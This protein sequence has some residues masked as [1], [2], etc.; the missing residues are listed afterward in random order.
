MTT[1]IDTVKPTE[2]YLEDILLQALNGRSEEEYLT[3]Y[4]DGMV[5]RLK[6]NPQ[7]YHLYGPWWPALKTL[8]LERGDISFGQVVDSDV[9]EIYKMSRPALTVLAGHLYSSD[10]LGNDAVYNPVHALEVA[11]YADDTEPYVYI[12]YDESIE[13]YRIMG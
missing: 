11:P 2:S 1:L 12:S 13:K 8:L 5:E 7:L 9:A 6:K 3:V 10:R 4:L